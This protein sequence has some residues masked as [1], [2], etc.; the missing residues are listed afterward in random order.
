MA[1]T[2]VE[3]IRPRLTDTRFTYTFRNFFHPFVGELIS[4][5][6]QDSLAKMLDPVFLDGLDASTADT[7]ES[8][9]SFF[10]LFRDY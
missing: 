8:P 7:R 3:R 10:K 6:N 4:K 5:L 1:T 9:D 2:A